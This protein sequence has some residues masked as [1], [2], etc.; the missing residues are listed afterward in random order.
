MAVRPMAGLHSDWYR[1]LVIDGPG[2]SATQPL[3]EDTGWWRGSNLYRHTSGLYVLH[4]GQSGCVPL[5]LLSPP[6]DPMP[7]MSCD[8]VTS[9]PGDIAPVAV[10]QTQP[11]P[12]SRFYADFTYIGHFAETPRNDDAISFIPADMGPE[13]ELPDIL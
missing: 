1:K 13:P 2:G 8:K 7:D 11:F 12:P 5:P 3:F 6:P 4:E 10:D 9:D